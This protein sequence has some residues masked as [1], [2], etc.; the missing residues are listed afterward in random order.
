MSPVAARSPNPFAYGELV[1]DDTF[2]DR[3][4]ELAELA[5]DVR[6]GLSV[7]V[8]APRR[9]GKSSL[10]RA[11]LAEVSVDGVLA[12]EVDLMT[13]PTKE[14]LAAKLAKSIHDEV[15]STLFRAK[16]RLRVFSG[17]RVAPSMTVDS[18]GAVSFTFAASRDPG[19][20]DATIERLLE[21]PGELAADGRRRIAVFFDEFQEV[22]S[23]DPHLP[24][25]MRSV[26]QRQPEVAHLYAGSRR[27]MMHRL[28]VDKHEPFYRSAKVVELG[29]ISADDFAGYI[30]ARFDATDRGVADAAVERLLEITTGHPSATQE[31]A[32]AL[33]EQVPEGFTAT[34]SDLDEAL[35]AVLRAEN[36]RFTLVWENATRP[37]KL[38]L[39]AFAREPGRPFGH[40]YRL[41]HDLPPASGVQRALRPLHEQ[42]QVAKRVDGLYDLAEPFLREWILSRAL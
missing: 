20:I 18:T 40:G 33:W 10:V 32:Y 21:L 42:E 30:H 24:G 35:R 22:T 4:R 14:R 3:T 39:Q 5:S 25:L 8:I 12:I 38:L 16:E 2:T 37:Q 34:A 11:A 31:L 9:Y 26:F 6:N 29:A 19:D 36:A 23:I 7:A 1:A 41:A 17:L 13:T 15:A 27:D 28:F